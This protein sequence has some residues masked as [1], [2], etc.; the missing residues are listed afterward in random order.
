MIFGNK[1]QTI[2]TA[3]IWLKS[4]FRWGVSEIKCIMFKENNDNPYEIH[5]IYIKLNIVFH[6]IIIYIG[7]KK[8]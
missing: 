2:K 7:N 4:C 5:N 3:K 1:K 6:V 8:I